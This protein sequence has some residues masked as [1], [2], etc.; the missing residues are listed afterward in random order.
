MF[1]VLK[2][3]PFKLLA[4]VSVN[5][6]KDTWAVNVLKSGPTIVDPTKRHATKLNLCDI[7]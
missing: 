5:Y 2:I 7:K 1:M 6:G 4:V 3:I